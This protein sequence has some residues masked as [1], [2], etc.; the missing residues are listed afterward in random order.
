MTVSLNRDNGHPN[1]RHKPST[2]RAC[3]ALF[4]YSRGSQIIIQGLVC[5]FFK[6]ILRV[7]GIFLGSGTPPMASLDR[8][9]PHP[10][11]HFPAPISTNSSTV[12]WDFDFSNLNLSP[13]KR[14][15]VAAQTNPPRGKW[16][17]ID[18]LDMR[19]SHQSVENIGFC[20]GYWKFSGGTTFPF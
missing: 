10:R 15:R 11:F 13:N 5:M 17:Y 3:K 12:V 16:S 14:C 20:H 2:S 6:N 19:C 8:N 1:P 9:I 7:Q 18:P 4:T